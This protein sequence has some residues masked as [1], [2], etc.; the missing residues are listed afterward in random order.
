MRWVLLWVV[1]GLT[2]GGNEEDLEETETLNSGISVRINQKAIDYVAPLAAEALH[3]LLENASVPTIEVAVLT[4]T[5]RI[6]EFHR[7]LIHGHFVKDKGVHARVTIPR[8]KIEGSARVKLAFL[9]YNERVKLTIDN[10][11]VTIEM[12]FSRDPKANLMKKEH[13]SIHAPSVTAEFEGRGINWFR[14]FIE[15]KIVEAVRDVVCQIA[16][17]AIVFLGDQNILP[18]GSIGPTEPPTEAGPDEV[19]DTIVDFALDLCTPENL[20]EG[21]T[22]TS[23]TTTTPD[24]SLPTTPWTA[25]PWSIDLT[26]RYLPKFT[27]EDV[28]FGLDGGITYDWNLP[29]VE[30]PPPMSPSLLGKKMLGA[31]ISDYVPNT[32]FAHIYEQRIGE[33]EF[34]VNTE[35]V[36]MALR[37]VAKMICSDCHIVGRCKLARQPLVEIYKEGGVSVV[38]AGSISIVLLNNKRNGTYDI[39]DATAHMHL[40][41]QPIVQNNRIFGDVKLTAVKVEIKKLGVATLIAKPIEKFVGFVVQKMVWP[42]LRRKLRFALHS[43]GVQLPVMCGIHL[44]NLSVVYSHRAIILQSDARYDVHLF[45]SKFKRYVNMKLAEANLGHVYAI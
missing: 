41:L 39:I 2:L 12:H 20:E 16:L 42:A 19:L 43:R 36:P 31:I 10:A 9:Y 18:D 1:V 21:G 33:V 35:D 27:D 26:L 29:N 4:I 6:H 17:D 45:V 8:A 5:G 32:F 3:H 30:R 34:D 37:T 38:M 22:T 25:S 23:T 7:P 44:E 24:P 14:S 13:C 40:T 11:T 15:R 28:T